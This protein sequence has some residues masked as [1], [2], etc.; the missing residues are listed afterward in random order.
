MIA[1]VI[2]IGLVFAIVVGIV[3][4][5]TQPT[6]LRSLMNE[7]QARK[8]L[9]QCKIRSEVQLMTCNDEVRRMIERAIRQRLSH[10]HGFS[11]SFSDP[12]ESIEAKEREHRRYNREKDIE[13]IVKRMA[14]IL[15]PS[16][17]R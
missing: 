13:D 5:C 4:M 10:I 9:F 8:M 6:F 2:S 1:T 3:L 7:Y 17:S 15:E 12:Y 16:D 11:Y 14:R